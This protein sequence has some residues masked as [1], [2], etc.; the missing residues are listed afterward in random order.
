MND[1]QTWTIV[2]ELTGGE[3]GQRTAKGENWE[4]YNR[5]TIKNY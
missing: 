4:K 2:W 5:I 3:D 1:P